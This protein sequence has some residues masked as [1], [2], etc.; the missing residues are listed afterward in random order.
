[1]PLPPAA[2]PRQGGPVPPPES[3]AAQTAV[4]QRAP[5][6]V[7]VHAGQHQQARVAV[8]GGQGGLG[9]GGVGGAGVQQ[10]LGVEVGDRGAQV[11][12]VAPV[13]VEVVGGGQVAGFVL[14]AVDDQQ[15]VA[16]PVQLLD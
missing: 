5:G 11:G 16:V 7:D 1:M 10:R 4:Q 13:A 6:A 2:P 12:Q 8:D 3:R 9:V 14:A 15:L